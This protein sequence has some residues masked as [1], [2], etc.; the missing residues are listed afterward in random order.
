MSRRNRRRWNGGSCRRGAGRS[1]TSGPPA[2]VRD[3]GRFFSLLDEQL[4][5]GTE[6]YSPR[7]L[8]KVEYAGA[9][10]GSFEQGGRALKVLAELPIS[11]KHVQRI[12]ER[13][14]EERRRQQDAEVTSMKAGTLKPAHPNPP[15]VAAIHLDAG[16]LQLREEDGRPGVREPRWADSK[17]GCFLTY[18]PRE[19][20]SDPQPKPPAVFLDPPRVMRL[21]GEMER[22]RSQPSASEVESTKESPPL[23]IEEHEERIERPSR[24]V[25]TAV[26][27]LEPTEPFGWMV[28]AEARRRGF[29]EAH[30]KAVVGDGGNWIGPLADMHFPGWVQVL[31]FLHLLV[32]L[33]AA[34]TAAYD[35]DAKAAWRLYDR[36]LRWAWAGDVKRL[37]AGLEEEGRRLGKPPPHA[38]ESDPRRIVSKTLDY[39]KTNEPRMDYARYRCEGLPIT[40][41][42]VESLIKQF[43]QRVK[44][45]EK[46]WNKGGAE[47]VLQIRAA[48]LSEDDRSDRFH[49]QRPRGQAVGRNR[50]KLAA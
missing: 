41:A 7:L 50:G 22:V 17:V 39:I 38:K 35:E 11:A 2:V 8:Q 47:S 27:T 1:N 48:Y 31:D 46:F 29:Y 34:A 28:S 32:H 30:H 26:A 13:L 10:E 45:T 43:N 19:G 9:N 23:V 36:W 25:R 12:T 3:V 14:G 44:G 49:E 18:T 21:C 20:T 37:L 24:L 5:L 42:A 16:K 33:Y 6:G 40:S 4:K 15:M